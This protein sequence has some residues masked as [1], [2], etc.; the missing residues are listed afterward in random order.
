LEAALYSDTLPVIV[1]PSVGE[2][3]KRRF[4]QGVISVRGDSR[5]TRDIVKNFYAACRGTISSFS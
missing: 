3:E 4:V 1:G 5:K 2:A